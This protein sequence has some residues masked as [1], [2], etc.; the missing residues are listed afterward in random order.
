MPIY[1]IDGLTPVWCR[2]RLIPPDRGVLIGD[3][4]PRQGSMLGP[5]ASLRG[6]LGRIVVKDGQYSG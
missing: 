5:N 1:Q 3:A 2:R 4:D 6:D